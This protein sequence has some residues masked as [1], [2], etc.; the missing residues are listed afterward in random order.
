MLYSDKLL[1]IDDHSIF[2]RHYY[3][4]VGSKRVSLN[5]IQHIEVVNP[6]LFSGKYRIHGTGDFR[7]WYPYDGKRP[8]RDQIFIITLKKGWWRIGFTVE[9]SGLVQLMLEKHG[10]IKEERK[11]GN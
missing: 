3:F 7:T 4:P 1:E 11:C 8:I 6:S 5:Q 9:R 10:L 2:F